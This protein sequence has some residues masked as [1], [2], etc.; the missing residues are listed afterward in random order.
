MANKITMEPPLNQPLNVFAT[1][2]YLFESNRL[3][4]KK[5]CKKVFPISTPIYQHQ[6]VNK[7]IF[8]HT[9]GVLLFELHQNNGNV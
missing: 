3:K 8:K 7:V 6:C 9:F 2:C 5:F 4:V 1:L